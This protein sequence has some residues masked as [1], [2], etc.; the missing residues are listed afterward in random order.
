MPRFVHCLEGPAKQTFVTWRN[1]SRSFRRSPIEFIP[2]GPL[3][4]TARFFMN[5]NEVLEP[6]FDALHVD[7]MERK[8]FSTR[9]I[10]EAEGKTPNSETYDFVMELTAVSGSEL[11][12]V[13]SVRIIDQPD[14]LWHQFSIGI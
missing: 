3:I 5:G 8:E 2:S 4:M 9:D 12:L 13:G 11:W 1:I 10:I 14:T 7:P 6:T